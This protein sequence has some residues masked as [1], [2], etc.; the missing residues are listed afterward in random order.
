VALY[1]VAGNFKWARRIG[2]A[3]VEFAGGL[4]VDQNDRVYVSSRFEGKLNLSIGGM[5]TVLTSAGK[6][7]IFM[8]RYSKNGVLELARRL[9][10]PEEDDSEALAVDKQ[11]GDIYLTGTQASAGKPHVFLARY[12]ALGTL[13]WNKIHPGNG[14]YNRANDLVVTPVGVYVVGKFSGSITFPSGSLTAA[15]ESDLFVAHYP[16][17][18]NGATDWVKRFGGLG[19][20][21]VTS[22]AYQPWE[23]GLGNA[24]LYLTGRFSGSFPFGPSTLS[25]SVNTSDLFLARLATNGTPDWAGQLGGSSDSDDEGKSISLVNSNTLYLLGHHRT[26]VTLGNTTLSGGTVLTRIDLPAVKDFQLIKAATDTD[27]KLLVS[28]AEINYY[29]LGSNQINIRANV[30]EGTAKSV[31]FILDGVSKTDNWAPFTWAGDGLT[32]YG[33]DYLPFTPALGAHTLEVIPYSGFNATGIAGRKRILKFTVVDKPVL[34]DVTLVNAL[35]DITVKSLAASPSINYALLNTKLIN[36]VA[37]PN[38][39]KVGSVRFTLDGV[40]KYDNTYPYSWA[41][42]QL[43]PNGLV[44]FLPFTPAPGTHTLKVTAYAQAN[45]LGTASN[46]LEISFTVTDRA[47]GARLATE[48]APGEAGF[49]QLTAAPNPFRGQTSLAFTAEADGPAALEVYNSQGLP[50]ARLFE[51]TVEKGKAYQWAFDGSAQPAGVYFAR[52]RA[53]NQVLH[54]RLVLTK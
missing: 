45:G 22:V 30:V 14:D 20:E 42:E 25:V 8:A 40:T 28:P 2:G 35:V 3:G 41:G 11:T 4:D 5:N 38:P 32:P 54:Q 44:D 43:K 36:L 23:E 7:D 13:K 19:Y 18:L 37:L 17:A 33:T 26:S 53:G 9:G 49:A 6:T 46:T 39:V 24:Y 29:T 52:L 12:D 10:G 31:K 47:A 50:V 48:D 1:D 27:S 34:N 15:G 16:Y 21:D 51:G